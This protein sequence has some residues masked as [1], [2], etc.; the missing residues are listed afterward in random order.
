[1]ARQ[2]HYL[3]A[4][5]AL[6]DFASRDV[7]RFF[8]FSQPVGRVFLEAIW[9]LAGQSVN[10]RLSPEGLDFGVEQLACG[11]SAVVVKLPDPIE[12]PEAYFAAIVK[13]Q[14]GNT[15]YFTLERSIP[16]DRSGSVSTMLGGV[17]RPEG[18]FGH[19]NYGAGPVPDRQAFVEA[20]NRLVADETT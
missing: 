13:D 20:V 12:P 1:M 10:D 11:L 15:R 19:V 17:N 9:D 16:M 6:P 8:A 3:F 2:H 18:K 14:A 4:F 5:M 7:D